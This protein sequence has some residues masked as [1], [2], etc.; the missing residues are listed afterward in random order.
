MPTA[1][2]PQKFV[3][4]LSL[5]TES[6]AFLGG[7]RIRLLEAID[8]LGS[9]SSAAKSIPLSY[10]AAW[11]AVDA[12]NNLADE[13]LVERSVGGAHGGG[14]RLTDH[15]RRIVAFYRALEQSQQEILDRCAALMGDAGARD[16]ARFRSLLH[17]SAMKSSARNQFVGPVTA[18]V[19]HD[20]LVD[21]RLRIDDHNEVAAL[22]TRDSAQ[23]LALAIGT[24]VHALVKAPSVIPSTAAAPPD[25]M[26][27]WLHGTVTR[28]V[29]S[30]QHCEVTVQLASG[31]SVVALARAQ[32]GPLERFA[33]GV[34]AGAY[35]PESSVILATF[36]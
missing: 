25:G 34:S 30:A 7:A 27:N 29:P 6:G 20:L 35:F 5:D 1:F 3:G 18:L 4:H 36:D 21:V 12:M 13:A 19:A 31:R 8:R 33:P 14:T 24:E 32:D 22:I 15:G 10:K 26:R 11:D 23:H 17:R 2:R 16:V 28:V 9:I